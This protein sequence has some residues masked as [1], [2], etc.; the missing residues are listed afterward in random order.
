[1]TSNYSNGHEAEKVAAEYLKSQ[2]YEIVELNWKTPVCEVDIVAKK[3]GVV[4]FVE[5][6]YRKNDAQGRGL[7]YITPKKLN[8]MKYAANCWVEENKYDGDFELS[9]IEMD[10]N[11]VVIEFI[12]QID[13]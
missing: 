2:G 9:A 13:F 5:V 3:V 8:Q 4:F 7:D 10:S 11:F 1:M 6:K 12:E